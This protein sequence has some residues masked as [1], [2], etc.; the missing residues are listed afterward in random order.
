MTYVVPTRELVWQAL[1][2]VI[3][4]ATVLDETGAAVPAFAK[5]SRRLQLMPDNTAQV[6]FD[7][8]AMFLV[9]GDEETQWKGNRGQPLLR[10]WRGMIWVFAKVPDGVRPG[11]PD[12]VTPGATVI[13]VLIDAIEAAMGPDD[14][15]LNLLTLGGLVSR[16]EIGGT[17]IK[18]PGDLNPEGQCFAAIPINIVVP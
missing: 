3:A 2:D 18:V 9:E 10:T 13:N 16:V 14:V 11:S 5:T 15:G 17:T 6:P 7:Q 1:F 8:P 4:A 12:F